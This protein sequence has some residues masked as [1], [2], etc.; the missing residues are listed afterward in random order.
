MRTKPWNPLGQPCVGDFCRQPRRSPQTSASVGQGALRELRV[1]L[2]L[3]QRLQDPNK[4]TV[5]ER[6][7]PARTS[8]NLHA[9]PAAS[10]SLQPGWASC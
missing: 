1:H 8:H 4:T 9:G 5:E 7:P 3:G 10:C 2:R 6:Q